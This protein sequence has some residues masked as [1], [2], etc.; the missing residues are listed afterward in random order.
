MFVT[1]APPRS[2]PRPFLFP[3]VNLGFLDEASLHG[4][5]KTWHGLARAI[6]RGLS[7]MQIQAYLTAAA[8]NL[9]RLAAALRILW[10]RLRASLE[11]PVALPP[12]LWLAELGSGELTTYRAAVASPG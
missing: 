10:S 1:A 2:W 7:N 6:R 12:C 11:I 4:E 3:S 5:A 8:I 9:K